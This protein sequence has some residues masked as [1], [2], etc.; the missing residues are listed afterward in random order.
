MLHLYCNLVQAGI[1]T[2]EDLHDV[3]DITELVQ[4]VGLS[5]TQAR[6]LMKASAQVWKYG[7]IFS[8]CTNP[9]I[10]HRHRNPERVHSHTVLASVPNQ[11]NA[12]RA[13]VLEFSTHMHSNISYER[14]L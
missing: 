10:V 6:K 14:V 1:S 5:T 13:R 8:T 3:E 2:V 9:Y 12:V 7:N 4:A 11:S